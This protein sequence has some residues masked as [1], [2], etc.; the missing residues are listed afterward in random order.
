MHN[1]LQGIKVCQISNLATNNAYPLD[2]ADI[3]DD[4]ITIID[5]TNAPT[6]GDGEVFPVEKGRP[7]QGTHM[8]RLNDNSNALFMRRS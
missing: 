8:C 3:T 6:Q 1:H 4:G 5:V 7:C 2:E